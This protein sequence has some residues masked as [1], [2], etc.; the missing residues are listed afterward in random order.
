MVFPR[1][2][3]VLCSLVFVGDLDSLWSAITEFLFLSL[4]I[5]G[6]LPGF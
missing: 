5:S 1:D 4:K 6:S 3:N 2:A